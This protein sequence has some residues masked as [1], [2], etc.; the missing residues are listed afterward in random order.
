MQI[1]PKTNLDAAQVRASLEMLVAE[2]YV[3]IQRKLELA[4]LLIGFEQANHYTIYN[5]HGIFPS[6]FKVVYVF[7]RGLGCL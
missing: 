3:A 6:F 7:L 5:R 2:P 4:N 1:V